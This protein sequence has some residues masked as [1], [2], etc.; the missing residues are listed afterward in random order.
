MKKY[1]LTEEEILADQFAFNN[2]HY[3]ENLYNFEGIL[4]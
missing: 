1:E 3:F 2:L 4:V